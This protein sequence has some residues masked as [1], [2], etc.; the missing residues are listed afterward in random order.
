MLQG[1]VT[2]S[3]P[4]RDR[5][6]PSNCWSTILPYIDIIVSVFVFVYFIAKFKFPVS[7]YTC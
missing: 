1:R 6:H 5:D 4:S 7:L 3:L 2:P